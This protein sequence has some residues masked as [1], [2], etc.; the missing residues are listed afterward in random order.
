MADKLQDYLNE[1]PSVRQQ[2]IS[3]GLPILL[4]DG[5]RML[6]GPAL[7]SDNAHSGWVDLTPENMGA[8]P[9]RIEGILAMLE[10]QLKGESSSRHH[11]DYPTLREWVEEDRFEIGEMVAWVSINE[12][13]GR[14]GKE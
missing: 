1:N 13:D 12:D 5:E 2:I 8:W 4:P 11:R 6:R 9:R 14:R 10:A 3:I 7:K